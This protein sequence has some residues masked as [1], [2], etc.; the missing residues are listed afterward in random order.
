MAPTE[1]EGPYPYPGGEIHNPLNRSDVTGGQTGVALSLAFTLVNTNSSCALLEGYR[2]DIWHCNAKGYYSGYGNQPGVSGTL[3]Y[4]G[5]DW[6][7]GYQTTDANGKLVFNT[8]YPGWYSG[9]A[10]HIHF[11]VYNGTKLV[12]TG[13]LT[14]PETISDAIHITSGYNGSIN[15]TRNVSDSVF[16]NSATDLGN[17]TMALTGSIAAGYV[18]THAIGVAV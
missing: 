5:A 13:Q 15:T 18:A 17:Q 14:M 3:S 16:G 1:T 4:V 10:T 7:R 9:R 2:I 6:L 11:E 12:K 8:I